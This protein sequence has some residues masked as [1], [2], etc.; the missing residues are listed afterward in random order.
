MPNR[1]LIDDPEFWRSRAEE[2]RTIA[3]EMKDRHGKTIMNRIA[4]DYERLAQH[5]EQR[6]RSQND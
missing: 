6:R 2:V 3:E 4:D 5:A 1:K